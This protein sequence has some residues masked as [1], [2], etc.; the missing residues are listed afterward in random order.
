[1]K[2]LLK[3][4]PYGRL[5]VSYAI[6]SLGR[7]F[8]MVAVMIL[9]GYLWQAEPLTI[10]L[11]PI[12]Y[13]LPAVVF[14]QF[15]AV[16]ADKINKIRLMQSADAA[17]AILTAGLIFA[18]GPPEALLILTLRA[19]FSVIHFPA[20]QSLVKE[21]VPENLIVKAVTLNGS[22]NEASKIIGPFLGGAL[23][24][25]FSPQLCIALNAA[26]HLFSSMILH[27]AAKTAGAPSASSIKQFS[28]WENWKDGWLYVVRH[29]P[30][31]LSI[32]FVLAA[33]F[34]LQMVDVQIAVL[35]RNTAPGQPE[36]I[37]WIMGSSGTGALIMMIL[38]QRLKEIRLYGIFLG[39]SMLLLGAG[40]GG[41]G[42][43]HQGMPVLF[44]VICGFAAG[45]GVGIF[46]VTIGAVLHRETSEAS[47]TRVSGIYNSLSNSVVLAAPLA[48]GVLTGIFSPVYVF[49]AVA[50]ALLFLGSLG[51]AF[52]KIFFA[53][54]DHKTSF[55]S[56]EAASGD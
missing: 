35:L 30:L 18:P 55:S 22:V 5:F 26:A 15:A 39:C 54:P 46:S 1:M 44:P 40:F 41:I 10:A 27:P 9:F 38:L 49:L 52:Q 43:F 17:T 23:A 33:L 13:A 56:R 48:G 21:I 6:S 34:F 12:A 50:S 53:P 25:G 51:I 31:W 14:S 11:I 24:A 36:L 29:R 37:G 3:N 45:L 47:I 8:D 20:Q 42:I 2:A 19:C 7:W 4:K 16:W 32:S 28:F